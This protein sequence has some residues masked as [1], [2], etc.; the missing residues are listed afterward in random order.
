[1]QTNQIGKKCIYFGHKKNIKHGGKNIKDMAEKYAELSDYELLWVYN[2]YKEQK[3][4]V[5]DVP[6]LEEIAKRWCWRGDDMMRK[7]F[8]IDQN[9]VADILDQLK[10]GKKVA[11]IAFANNVPMEKIKIIN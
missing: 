10:E 4:N 3:L 7:I 8:T 1:M 9:K 11:D 2:D 5:P 6:L